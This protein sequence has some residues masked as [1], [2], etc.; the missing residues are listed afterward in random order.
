LAQGGYL[1]A[2]E[3]ELALAVGVANPSMETISDYVALLLQEAKPREAIDVL[4]RVPERRRDNAPYH[5]FL[6]QTYER[7]PE[8]ARAYEEYSKAISLDP[9]REEYY[10]S[11]ASL[12]LSQ[13]ANSSAKKVVATA[14]KRF[15]NSVTSLVAMGLVELEDG[16][17]QE[18][19]QDY[20]TALQAEPNSPI[21]CKLL[22]GIQSASGDYLEAIQ[23]F[24]KAAEL[25]PKDPQAVFY[26]GLA[27]AKMQ[28]GTEKAI[29][30]FFRSLKLNP[31]LADRYF[32]I[33]SLYLH[34]EHKYD[35]AER[36]LEEAVKR[37]PSW[38]PANQALIQCYRIL[39]KDQKVKALELRYKEAVQQSQS[40]PDLKT[41]LAAEG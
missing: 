7:L 10:I 40:G 38:A 24:E 9:S 31:Q 32:W 3:K 36:Y 13:Q 37:A 34:R 17:V 2:A 26:E 14:L 20:R 16:N 1:V 41:L 27:Y 35:L 15:P 29:G 22:G 21:A 4:S 5:Y 25:D 19:M 33:G 30:C 8:F 6:G 23:T 28:D 18:A 11:L 39:K 12:L